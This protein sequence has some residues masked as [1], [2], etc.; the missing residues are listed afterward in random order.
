MAVINRFFLFFS[1][2]IYKYFSFFFLFSFQSKADKE[3]DEVGVDGLDSELPDLVLDTTPLPER[4]F[5]LSVSATNNAEE[6][7]DDK[8]KG[9]PLIVR[10]VLIADKEVDVHL[11]PRAV[12]PSVYGFIYS[13]F[14]LQTLFF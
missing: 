11:P 3:K 14:I 12:N 5:P 7:D 13:P 9:N 8:P 4:I 6:V 1:T 2:I 10:H